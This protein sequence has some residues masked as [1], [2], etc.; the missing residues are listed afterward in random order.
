MA[1]TVIP[2]NVILQDFLC[3][4]KWTSEPSA[5]WGPYAID[6]MARRR[7]WELSESEIRC[8]GLG[9][10][11]LCFFPHIFGTV[12]CTIRRAVKVATCYHLWCWSRRKIEVV[13]YTPLPRPQ[14]IYVNDFHLPAESVNPK[15]P[16]IAED[17]QEDELQSP[18]PSFYNTISEEKIQ[19]VIA[20]TSRLTYTR[21]EKRVERSG[22]ERVGDAGVEVIKLICTPVNLVAMEFFACAMVCCPTNN[23]RKLYHIFEEMQYEGEF[24]TGFGC[25]GTNPSYEEFSRLPPIDMHMV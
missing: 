4:D 17:E 15:L 25:S 16:S 14:I 24:R 21:D 12:F 2:S 13:V 5:F 19:E 9:T 6:Q 22:K 3:T 23:S 8:K 1:I 7:Y 11:V 20:I 10:A 18:S